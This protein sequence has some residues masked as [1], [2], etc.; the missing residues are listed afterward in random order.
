MSDSA[1]GQGLGMSRSEAVTAVIYS[2][3]QEDT[4]L[5]SLLSAEAANLWKIVGTDGVSFDQILAASKNAQNTLANVAEIEIRLL[6]KLTAL[7]SGL[8]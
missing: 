1:S 8:A 4:A 7:G 3:A 2:I 5:A 6:G